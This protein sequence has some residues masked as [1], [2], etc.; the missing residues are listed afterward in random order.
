MHVF[1]LSEFSN[2][3]YTM[4][5]VLVGNDLKW[6]FLYNENYFACYIALYTNMSSDIKLLKG[7]GGCW[8][9]NYMDLRIM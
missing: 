9:E 1:E 6:P 3:Y 7:P 2:A 8:I 4:Y 5:V